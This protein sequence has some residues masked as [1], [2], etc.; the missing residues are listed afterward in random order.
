VTSPPRRTL[1]PASLGFASH[2]LAGVLPFI[3]AGA[4]TRLGLMPATATLYLV[5]S[6]VLA[7]TLLHRRV[8]AR[9]TTET[10]SLVASGR[11]TTFAGG[12]AGFLVAGVAYYVGL[13]STTRVAEYI[14]LT[15]LDW[16][17]QA[18]FA[19]VWLR[20][21]WTGRGLVGA[22]LALTGGV[23]LAWS[24][25]FGTSGLVAAGIYIG[26]SL[27]GYSCFKPLSTDRGPLG[28]VALTM[29]R[30]WV[31]TI[32]FVALAIAMPGTAVFADTT[33]LLLAM[34]A[35]VVIVVLFLLRFTAL[36]GLPLWVLSAL[37]PTQA[38]VA[39]LA[40]LATGGTVPEL[41]LIAMGLIVAGE[42]LVARARGSF[43]RPPE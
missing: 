43:D 19:I 39:I 27:V 2:L 36:V 35:G 1:N 24:G 13:A 33:G 12:L 11:R 34:V 21:P 40:T 32:G 9:L 8:R 5:G 37:A 10:A 14:F 20:E 22:A 26:A 4:I 23:M 38:L 18:T 16:L 25:T 17:V 30:H 41:T 15:R 3:S 31:N 6:V 29:W 42:V 7:A 28:A